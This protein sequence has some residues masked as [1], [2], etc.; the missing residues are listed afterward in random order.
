MI[1]FDRNAMAPLAPGVAERMAQVLRRTDLGNPSSVHARGRAARE[2]VETAR[3]QVATAV[4]AAPLEVTFTAGG[5]EADALAVLGTVGALRDAGRPHGVLT[6]PVE[7]PAVTAAVAALATGGVPTH[8][9]RV[10]GHGRIDPEQVAEELA[11]R[12]EVGLVSL[13]AANHELGNRYDI[14]AI[15]RAVRAVR[16][17]VVIHSDAVAAFGK[18]DVD[19]ASWGVDLLSISSPKIG[20][21][22]GAGALV[23]RAFVRLRPLWFG[24]Q[25]RGRR[26]GTEATWLLAGFGEAAHLAATERA[27]RSA[28]CHEL[29]A[30]LRR[31]VETLGGVVVGDPSDHVGTTINVGFPGCSGELVCIALDLEGFAV[32]TGAACSAGSVGPSPVLLALGLPVAQARRAI[33]ISLGHDHDEHQID[34][35]LAALPPILN[36]IRSAGAERGQEVS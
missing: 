18:I 29:L 31:G 5:T 12:P 19:F 25:E 13:M 2:V 7:H 24:H 27:G 26:G 28:R 15:T 9:V 8:A 1:D 3:G 35:L 10:D 32:S 22:P 36:R 21:P 33:R 14:P 34:A 23:H 20:G 30:R 11:R 4:G 6:S 17:D 16:D